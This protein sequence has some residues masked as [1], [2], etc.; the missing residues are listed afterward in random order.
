MM[1]T[2]CTMDETASS[3]DGL[4]SVDPDGA[5]GA[6]PAVE[7]G[8]ATAVAASVS[9]AA[10]AA[11]ED[12]VSASNQEENREWPKPAQREAGNTS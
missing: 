1:E 11:G 7:S 10:A 3:T 8:P 5:P 4:G 6:Q 2:V 9:A 12:I